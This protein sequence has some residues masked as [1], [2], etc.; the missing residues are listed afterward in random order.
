MNS[1]VPSQETISSKRPISAFNIGHLYSHEE[2]YR[3]LSVGNAGGI[4]PS[5]RADGNL[6]RLV[7]FTA[8][9]SAKIAR[10][11]PYADRMEGDILVYTAAGREG[12]QNLT[13]GKRSN[14]GSND[15]SLPY[16]LLSEHGQSA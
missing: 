12:S 13:G 1:A 9:A 7:I 10:E 15:S 4:R 3:S 2:V 6:A 11:N 14:T 8:A 16:L 5:I